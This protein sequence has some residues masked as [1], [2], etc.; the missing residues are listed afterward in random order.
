M[1]YLDA[2]E[3]VWAMLSQLKVARF[4]ATF[5]AGNRGLFMPRYKGSLFR[6]AMGHAF[7]ELT[8][9]CPRRPG[10]PV[11]E[12]LED[13]IYQYLFETKL[14]K[15]LPNLQGNE[16]AVRPFL[17]LPPL[18]EKEYYAPGER[19]QLSFTLFGKGIDYLPFFILVL[20]RI[21]EMGLGK[22][23]LRAELRQVFYEDL[24]GDLF[25]IYNGEEKVL[26]K[27]YPVYEAG[28]LSSMPPADGE[29]NLYFLTPLRM[30][31][32]DH[33]LT[34]PNFKALVRGIIRRA[35]SLLLIHQER[36]VEIPDYR[37]FIE[38]TDRI[39][40][41]TDETRWFDWERY[42]N[43]QK[44]RM[45]LGGVVG[46]VTYSGPW[47]PYYRFLK[48]GE[49]IHVGKSTVFGLGKIKVIP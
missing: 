31:D 3:E 40:S 6:G 33:L 12:H 42:S 26:C 20:E 11:R 48:L 18:E 34:R 23:K 9:A 17:L 19:F 27:E 7:R 49:W 28:S 22:E 16:E 10:E 14:P 35:V 24:A 36:N 29:L 46:K 13:C 41:I 21:G 39:V 43:R 8:C 15:D 38:Q 5:Q 37:P 30:K 45:K 47:H 2:G 25:P 32:K 44:E 4:T 1:K